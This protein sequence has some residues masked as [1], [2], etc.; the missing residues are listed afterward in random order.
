MVREQPA[1]SYAA[2]LAIVAIVMALVGIGYLA[3]LAFVE[4]ILVPGEFAAYGLAITAVAAGTASFFS[5]CAFTML[6]SYI[7]FAGGGVPRQDRPMLGTTLLAGTAASLGVV[8]AVSVLGLLLAALGTGVGAN[9]S[10]TAEDPSRAAQGLRI[11]VGAFIIA[12][13]LMHILDWSH[14]APLVGKVASWAV[15]AQPEGGSVRALYAYGAGY[16]VVGIDWVN[17]PIPGCGRS[18]R[19]S[20]RWIRLGLLWCRA[21]H[22][23]HGSTD[24]AGIARGGRDRKQCSARAQGLGSADPAG[25]QCGDAARRSWPHL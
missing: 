6:P 2:A 10:V 9:L 8:T 11:G 3:F 19:N 25:G 7:A 21:V 14:R 1:K 12:M 18:L 16:A 23:H 13:G 24:A 5:P 20:D 22:R 15:R 17:G 4:G